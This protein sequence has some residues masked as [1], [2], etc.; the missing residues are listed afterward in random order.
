SQTGS[1]AGTVKDNTDAVLPAITLTITDASG[2]VREVSTDEK[3]EY[4]LGDLAPGSYTVS[5]DLQ[6][7]APFIA[8]D[9][10]VAAGGTAR[11]DVILL[12]AS[13][14]EKVNV[15]G[16]P[17]TQAETQSS[18][19]SGTITSKEL[20]ELMLNG[21]NFTQLIALTPG[22]SNQTGQDEALVGIKGSVKYSVNGGRVEYNSYEVDGGDILNAS[23]NGSNSTLIVYPSLDAIDSLQVLTSN[24][25]AEYG[26]SASG[27]TVAT[28]KAGGP[29]FHGDAYFFLRNEVFNARNFFDQTRRAPLYRKYDPGATI[30]GPLYIPGVYN[31]QKDKTFFFFSEEY[32]HEKEP[33]AF[34]QAVPSDIERTGNFSDICP[35]SGTVDSATGAGFI[36]TRSLAASRAASSVGLKVPYFPDCPG[37]ASGTFIPVPSTNPLVPS[38]VFPIF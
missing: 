17:V 26:R 28:T 3:G 18:Q 20:T 29:Q 37:T 23:I 36:F 8:K 16:N 24:Y 2:K 7:F 25:G 27:I 13:V 5:L 14:T 1:I 12:P 11:V 4:K 32:R 35:T 30:G 31:T 33:V 15:E 21:R 34:N 9:V 10:A 6:G 19:I 38:N 22:V